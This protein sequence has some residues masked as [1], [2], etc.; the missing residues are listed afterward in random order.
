MPSST[1]A[2]PALAS[3]SL[4]SSLS[5][6]QELEAMMDAMGDDELYDEAEAKTA[7]DDQDRIY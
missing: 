6:E 5:L 7:A 1:P 4:A 3:S 2:N